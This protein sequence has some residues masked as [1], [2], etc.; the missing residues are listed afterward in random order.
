MARSRFALILYP[1]YNA[2]WRVDPSKRYICTHEKQ[3]YRWNSEVQ[4]SAE[5]LDAKEPSRARRVHAYV[6]FRLFRSKFRIAAHTQGA[7]VTFH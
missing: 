7:D 4:A 2:R 3:L 1:N 6:A 5:N